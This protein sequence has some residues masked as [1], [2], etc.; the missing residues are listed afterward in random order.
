M[1]KY[2]ICINPKNLKR[3]ASFPFLSVLNSVVLE[4]LLLSV[5]HI[6]PRLL[7]VLPKAV[8]RFSW[9]CGICMFS[10]GI[11]RFSLEIAYVLPGVVSSGFLPA[12]RAFDRRCVLKASRSNVDVKMI[13]LA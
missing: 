11:A 10:P 9:E 13:K 8:I 1:E 5:A 6:S 2:Q 7:Y 4:H 3:L 12:K